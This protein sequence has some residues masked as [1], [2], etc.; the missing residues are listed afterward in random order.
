[1]GQ[2][3]IPENERDDLALVASMVFKPHSPVSE[4]EHFS[5][6]REELRKVIDAINQDGQ[7]AVIF[8]ERGVGKTSLANILASRLHNTGGTL[9]SPH[10]SCSSGESFSSI[11]RQVFSEIE[12]TKRV[13]R[14]GFTEE[15]TEE[16]RSLLDE[17]PDDIGPGD[18]RS[19]L[20]LLAT[21]VV[22]VIVIDEFDRVSSQK[23]KAQFADT[24]KMLSDY[25]VNT[26]IV[27]VGVADTVTDLISGHASVARALVEVPVPRMS[28]VELQLI[29]KNGLTRLGMNI[30]GDAVDHASFLCRGF[31]H[32]AHLL[33]LHASRRAIDAGTRLVTLQHIEAAIE[34]AVNNAHQSVRSAY[35]KA[36]A[37]PHKKSL[38]Q[39][40][41]LACALAPSDSMGF[42]TAGD[43]RAQFRKI[44]GKAD[45][46]IPNYA[47]HLNAFCHPD[48]GSV[49]EKRGVTHRPLYRFTNPL[50]QPFVVMQGIVDGWIEGCALS[51]NKP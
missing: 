46:D 5:G 11:W 30:T 8:G 15:A 26:T 20:R 42:F 36:V 7:H 38:H 32:F 40:V 23:T 21:G 24:I 44:T 3:D 4:N 1:M 16:I 48:R 13:K 51:K 6:R 28:G 41:L 19:A 39:Q 43:I 12:I 14:V 50:L 47:K 45:Y 29:L 34:I 18:V 31:P 10:V 33:G 22:L 49:L 2:F 9:I 25:T 35:Q 37:S 17:M 27:L